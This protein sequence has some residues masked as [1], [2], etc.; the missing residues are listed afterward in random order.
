M[1]RFIIPTRNRPASL[2]QLLKYL[3]KFY[4]GTRLLLADGS[5]PHVK[6]EVESVV[7]SYGSELELEYCSY[8]A[9]LPF[10][11][12]VLD[13]IDQT[14]DPFLAMGAD[15]DYP[16]VDVYDRAERM[17]AARPEVANVVPGDVLLS[18]NSPDKMQVRLSPSRDIRAQSVTS[19]TKKYASWS[20]ATSYG[21]TR[22]E[23]LIERYKML[24]QHNC[25]GFID[26]QIGTNDAISG[27][28]LALD[29]IGTIRTHSYL[30]SFFRPTSALVFLRHADR[31]LK[32]NDYLAKRLADSG[33]AID[34]SEALANRLVRDRVRE[35]TGQSAPG[36]LGFT[37]SL[38]FRDPK[39][40]EQ[41]RIFYA[42][43]EDGQPEREEIRE[44]LGF[45]GHSLRNEVAKDDYGGGNNYE[46][47]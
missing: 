33:V 10:F 27:S 45:V 5:D 11:E 43:F 29:A 3:V 6:P 31:I 15:D 39:L 46:T 16:L 35:L 26:F 14:D 37:D 30:H 23:V 28:I 12:R 44:H 7:S 9:D 42:L 2:A 22:R 17:I 21:V 1:P 8:P 4:P 18:L 32:Y 34:E 38:N 19:R 41:F 36:L 25:P 40:Q 13:A 47:L 24:A 20:F